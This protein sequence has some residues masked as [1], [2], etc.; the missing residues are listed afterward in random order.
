MIRSASK[1]RNVRVIPL[2]LTPIELEN[3][4][5]H[6]YAFL[7]DWKRIQKRGG[8]ICIN[9]ITN[10]QQ[11]KVIKKVIASIGNNIF[12]IIRNGANLVNMC[13]PVSI[14]KKE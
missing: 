4:T 10:S 13:L 6:E 7:T 12:K 9:P 1:F 11:K 8:L 5:L 2:D 14:F 3:K